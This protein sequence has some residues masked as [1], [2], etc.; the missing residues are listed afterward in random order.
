M[1]KLNIYINEEQGKTLSK[2]GKAK[3][4]E[5][6]VF[7][8]QHP[9]AALA[10]TI[11]TPPDIRSVLCEKDGTTAAPNPFSVPNLKS[12]GY[13]VCNDYQGTSFK[14]T[15]QVGTA[16]PEDPIIIIERSSHSGISVPI[17]GTVG[18]ALAAFILGAAIAMMWARSRT[19]PRS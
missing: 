5:K 1:A 19:A 11:V 8:N 7:N 14:Y 9:T 16:A 18:I 2:F 10:V 17:A 13:W 6:I 15:A 4:N 12:T 3:D